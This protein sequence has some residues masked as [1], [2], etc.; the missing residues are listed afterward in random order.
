MYKKNKEKLC[1]NK[2]RHQLLKIITG[3]NLEIKM[4]FKYKKE[5]NTSYIGNIGYIQYNYCK[6]L[7]S[8]RTD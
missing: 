6:I 4:L 1:C 3:N 2:G 5:K 8:I 7:F